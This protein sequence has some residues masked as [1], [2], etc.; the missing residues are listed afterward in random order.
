MHLLDELIIL[1]DD[2]S[3][4]L[5]QGDSGLDLKLLRA[6]IDHGQNFRDKLLLS[7]KIALEDGYTVPEYVALLVMIWLFQK[8]QTTLYLS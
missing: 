4:H 6:L 8:Q 2:F 1:Y 3:K 7:I 5:V